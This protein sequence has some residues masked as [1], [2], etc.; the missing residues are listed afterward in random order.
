MPSFQGKG[1]YPYAGINPS[2][3]KI[4]VRSLPGPLNRCY[5][6]GMGV[7]DPVFERITVLADQP[8]R[9]ADEPRL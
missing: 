5:G 3:R 9:R 8:R 4:N 7:T 1:L 6:I 2:N